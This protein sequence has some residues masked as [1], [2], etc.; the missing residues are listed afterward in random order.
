MKVR[1]LVGLWLLAVTPALADEPQASGLTLMHPSP[2]PPVNQSGPVRARIADAARAAAPP[3]GELSGLRAVTLREG[4][5]VISL[6]GVTR[7]VRPG[8]ALRSATVKSVGADRIVLE[9]SAPSSAGAPTIVVIRFGPDGE[10]RGRTY[11]PMIE[12]Q[13]APE[14]R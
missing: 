14:S 11:A 13:T 10:A 7:S 9:R 3:G 5:G 2:Q 8:D 6:D 12:A 4:S 1:R